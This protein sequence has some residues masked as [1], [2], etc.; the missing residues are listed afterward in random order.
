MR[1]TSARVAWVTAALL[2]ALAL[3]AAARAEP[4]CGCGWCER[5]PY[6]STPPGDAA[7]YG[8][9]DPV[10]SADEARRRL[11]AFYDSDDLVV[12]KASERLLY[13]EASIKHKDGRLVDRVIVDKRSG[14][15]R[16]ILRADP[17][18]SKELGLSTDP[19]VS[20][21]VARRTTT[22]SPVEGRR[23]R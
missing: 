17:S 14:R 18:A 1:R 11:E 7:R 4:G 19:T 2:G 16:S 9:K 12:G 10:R 15:I 22:W 13:F 6:G 23:R 3:P 8:A 5:R 21:G 20:E